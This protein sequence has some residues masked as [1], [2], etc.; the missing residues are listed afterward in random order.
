MVD[1]PKLLK[2]HKP[3]RSIAFREALW[4]WTSI[5]AQPGP[6]VIRDANVQ[7]GAMLIDENVRPVVVAAHAV[8]II[9][10]VSLRS[11]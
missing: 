10:D 4:L 8:E 3:V 2:P 9:R 5:L 11:T 6:E 7:C 1:V